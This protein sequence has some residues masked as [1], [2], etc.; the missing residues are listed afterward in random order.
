MTYDRVAAKDLFLKACEMPVAD[1]ARFLDHSCADQPELR[2]RVESLLGSLDDPGSFLVKPIM[3]ELDATHLSGAVRAASGANIEPGELRASLPFLE[4]CETPGRIGKLDTYEIIEV[5]GRG[6]MGFVLKAFDT[7]LQRIV[8]VKV[9]ATP[10]ATDTSAAKRF[11]REARAAAAVSHDHVVTIFAVQE[12][13]QCPY[14]V[15]ECIVGQSLQQK[16]DRCS[17]FRLKETLRI[18]MQI[19]AGLA[20]AH[21]QGLVHRDIKPSNILLENGVERVKLTDFGLAR[22]IDDA[23][24]TQTGHIAGTPQYMSPEQAMGEAV[25][26]RSDLFSLGCV[27]YCMCTGRPP[28]RGE[29]PVVVL[30][31]VCDEVPRPIREINA[32]VP[33]WLISII[34]KLLAKRPADRF[35]TAAEVADLLSNCLAWS[36][37]PEGQ[38][39]PS[40]PQSKVS[41]RPIGRLALWVGAVIVLC[42]ILWESITYMERHVEIVGSNRLSGGQTLAESEMDVQFG[43]VD[44]PVEGSRPK[45]L[46]VPCQ[47]SEAEAIQNEWSRYLKVPIDYTNALGIKFRLI[48]PGRFNMGNSPDE[49]ASLLQALKLANA[50]QFTLFTAESSVPHHRVQLV[51][52]FYMGQFEVTVSQFEHFVAET[53]Y[54]STLENIDSPRFT[55]K[56]FST[57]EATE[58]QPVCGVSWED[59][60][61]FCEWLSEK[62]R[63]HYSLPTEAQWEYACRAGNDGRWSFGDSELLLENYAIFGQD[64]STS[65]A[66]VGTKRPNAFGLYDMHGN[67]EEW[68]FD[69]HSAEFYKVS[70]EVDPVFTGPVND[71]A[72]GRVA[73]GGSWNA[74]SWRTRSAT[75]T[76]DFPKTPVFARGFRVAMTGNLT[77]AQPANPH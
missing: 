68:C 60:K 14:L 1:R 30:R 64:A 8:A 65:P 32:E 73:R 62:E 40:V 49:V 39:P 33:E 26:A 23:G 52:P 27:M 34:D 41:R 10:K 28:F 15:M 58:K 4:P 61:A 45:L 5:I 55:W 76:Y 18:A 37:K 21:K 51:Q 46:V 57:G 3:E 9:L 72:S 48:P 42:A 50:D 35:Q 29:T 38:R 24:I 67:V 75:R 6:G 31:R 63:A 47:E 44:A 36:Q 25:D 54:V 17:P 74:A 2:A 13:G 53:H 71:S 22:A 59:A 43:P 69:W 7:K 56:Q 12:H 11:L 77:R 70:P 66:A 20:A 19:A 16:I